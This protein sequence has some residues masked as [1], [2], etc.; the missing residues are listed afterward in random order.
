MLDGNSVAGSSQLPPQSNIAAGNE[1]SFDALTRSLGVDDVEG[2]VN[3]VLGSTFGDWAKAIIDESP[4]PTFL[5]DAANGAI[6]HAV[7]ESRASSSAEAEKSVDEQFRDLIEDIVRAVLEDIQEEVQEEG[8]RS[9]GGEQGGGAGGAAGGG[10]WLVAL[11]RAMGDVA[12]RHL[13][14]SVEAA[15]E[16]SNLGSINGTGEEADIARSN[17]AQKMA[18]LQAEMQADSQMF[19]LAQEA[20]TT[21][22][23]N[24]G[25]AL[26]TAARKQ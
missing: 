3:N 18:G 11:A 10:N 23:K 24:T 1:V 21:I 13:A 4:L 5:R 7:S 15:S 12:G 9:A 2:A 17:Q 25:E 19:K 22:V 8:E 6:D 16:I 20:T 26:T 14:N